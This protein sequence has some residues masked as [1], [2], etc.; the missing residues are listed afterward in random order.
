MKDLRSPLTIGKV[1]EE[2]LEFLVNGVGEMLSIA[3]EIYFEL[4][5]FYFFEFLLKDKN[6]SR[7]L[8]QDVLESVGF[9]DDCLNRF[10]N[11]W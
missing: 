7:K 2:V 5:N 3:F 11:G 1:T 4:E 10:E 9:L 8:V 6:D